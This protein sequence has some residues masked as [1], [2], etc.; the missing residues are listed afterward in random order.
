LFLS[1]HLDLG[2][3]ALGKQLKSASTIGT[4]SFMQQRCMDESER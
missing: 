4:I 3:L 1:S 2:F